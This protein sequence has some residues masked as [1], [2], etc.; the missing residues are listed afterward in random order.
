MP[1]EPER[2]C[3]GCRTRRPKGELLR[4]ARGD[5]R[6]DVD[7][8]GQGPGRGAYVCPDP[9]CVALAVRKGTLARVLRVAL[10]PDDLATLRREM[11]KEIAKR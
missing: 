5:G 4:V 11:E 9:A 7:P 10:G 1:R 8:S 6:V 2:S 3:V